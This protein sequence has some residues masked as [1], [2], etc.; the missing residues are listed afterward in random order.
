MKTFS[1]NLV[2]VAIILI[3]LAILVF[4]LFR[5]Q[6]RVAFNSS[7]NPGQ[8]PAPSVNT[9]L[10]SST[11]SGE[12]ENNALEFSGSTPPASI[13]SLDEYRYPGAKVISSS[14]TKLELE[15]DD[16]N[17][18][19]TDW[20]KNKIREDNFNAK[21]FTQTNSNGVV[22][23]KLSAAKPG[24]KIEITIKKDQNISTSTIIVDRSE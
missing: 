4:V 15:S 3:L 10:E 20:Y 1:P 17:Q 7:L 13:T 6:S 18:K 16:N 23:N 5:Q 11:G 21:S 24:D 2:I 19:I 8:S 12:M 22:L 14:N 9:S